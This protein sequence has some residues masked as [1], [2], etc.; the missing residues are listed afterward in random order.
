MVGQ[1]CKRCAA[2]SL[3]QDGT[4]TTPLVT[5][6]SCGY[7][8]SGL[9]AGGRCPECGN[10]IR[11]VRGMGR[12]PL[13]READEALAFGIAAAVFALLGVLGDACFWILI[14][15]PV[16]FAAARARAVRIGHGPGP[17]P[18]RLA[19]AWTGTALAWGSL[20]VVSLYVVYLVAF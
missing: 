5:C 8:L 14:P 11:I 10:H 13:S 6:E 18:P 15:L 3:A 16:L 20:V 1:F 7:D 17:L 4:P 9:M 12:A 2:D 19:R